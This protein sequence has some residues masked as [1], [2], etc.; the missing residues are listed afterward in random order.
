MST[1]DLFDNPIGAGAPFTL[2]IYQQRQ[3]ALLHLWTSKPYLEQL[4]KLTNELLFH[5]DE[6]LDDAKAY[7]RDTLLTSEQWGTRYTSENWGTFG[8][9]K[10][11]EYRQSVINAIIQLEND[12][13]GFTSMNDVSGWLRHNPIYWMSQDEEEYFDTAFQKLFKHDSNYYDAINLR[14]SRLEDCSFFVSVEEHQHYLQ[15]APVFQVNTRVVAESG[16]IPPGKGIYVPVDDELGTLQVG[17]N[18]NEYGALDDC[19]T[20]NEIGREL[21]QAV[22]RK[23]LWNETKKTVQ[24]VIQKLNSGELEPF[25]TIDSDLEMLKNEPSFS[26]GLL[27]SGI[28]TTRPCKWYLVEQVEG[29]TQDLSFAAQSI[30]DAQFGRL[31]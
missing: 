18:G 3:A 22:P 24:F 14:R 25:D 12:E 7:N 1:T 15:S 5:T 31:G 2:N 27:A 29:K 20:F 10:M 4:L 17:W 23:E 8:F 28:S 19:S 13:Y 16:K 6:A 9:P 26:H 11:V 21:L 30:N